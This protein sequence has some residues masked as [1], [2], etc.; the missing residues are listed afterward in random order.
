RSRTTSSRTASRSTRSTAASAPTSPTATSTKA[1][2][3]FSVR[4]RA[5]QIGGL[6]HGRRATEG[7]EPAPEDL[8]DLV[9]RV[10]LREAGVDGETQA[11]IAARQNDAVGLVRELVRQYRERPGVLGL[12]SD[13][14]QQQLVAG[15]GVRLSFLESGERFVARLERQHA[16]VHL[17]A[18]Q[19]QIDGALVGGTGD[20]RDLLARHVGKRAQARI[21]L[22]QQPGALDEGDA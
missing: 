3:S 8:H 19:L 13:A 10:D 5:E 18:L 7:A 2:F 6:Q 14:E 12:G 11:R 21:G 4:D 16:G 15:E 9:A 17:A 1:R 22:D 20:D